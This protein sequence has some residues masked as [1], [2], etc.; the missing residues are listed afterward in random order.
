M[1]VVVFGKDFV[2]VF[3]RLQ[4]FTCVGLTTMGLSRCVPNLNLHKNNHKFQHFLSA[5]ADFVHSHV[6]FWL[7]CAAPWHDRVH[8][9][10]SFHDPWWNGSGWKESKY[11]LPLPTQYRLRYGWFGLVKPF[12]KFGIHQN[13]LMRIPL[14]LCFFWLFLIKW[15]RDVDCKARNTLSN[16]WLYSPFVQPV[17]PTD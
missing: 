12:F 13:K 17:P 9:P 2:T 5:L 11:A 4:M 7:C 14:S 3:E 15:W 10:S 16:Y 8:I 1:V 6:F